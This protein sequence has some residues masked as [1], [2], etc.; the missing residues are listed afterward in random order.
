[1]KQSKSLQMRQSLLCS[2]FFSPCPRLRIH[3]LRLH[4]HLI[5]QLWEGWKVRAIY[6]ILTEWLIPSSIHT[7]RHAD[8]YS[9]FYWLWEK[10]MSVI[11]FFRKNSKRLITV[12]DIPSVPDAITVLSLTLFGCEGWLI[13]M[14]W[15]PNS[16]IT[17]FSQCTRLKQKV[18]AGTK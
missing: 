6:E 18:F 17:T 2:F 3:I 16:C 14:I 12:T 8:R 13:W 9:R 15:S 11:K 10:Y 4:R 5:L 7:L 1:M